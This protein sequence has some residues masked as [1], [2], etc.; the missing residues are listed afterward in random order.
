[1]PEPPEITDVA[2]PP[3]TVPITE[4]AVRF[5]VEIVGVDFGR[6]VV[7]RPAIVGVI[8]LYIM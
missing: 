3:P 1:M 4:V 7:T 8:A 2:V 6:L 5:R